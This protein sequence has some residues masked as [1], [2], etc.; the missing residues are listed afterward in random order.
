MLAPSSSTASATVKNKSVAYNNRGNAISR[1]EY[2]QAIVTTP[3]PELDPR[4]HAANRGSAHE[5]RRF[6][7]PS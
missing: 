7:R 4:A 5:Q 2:D 3:G 1:K 6:E